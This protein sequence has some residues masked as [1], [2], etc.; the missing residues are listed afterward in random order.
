M[1][2]LVL[3][4]VVKTYGRK[5]ALKGISFEIRSGSLVGLLGPNGAGKTTT[6]KLIAGLLKKDSGEI[7]VNGKD[8]YTQHS[9]ALRSV[10]ILIEPS[11]FPYLTAY[12]NLAYLCTALG[13]DKNQIDP[14]LEFV[15][16]S[17]ERNKKV[18]TFSFGMKQRLGLAQALLGNPSLII[19]D[20]PNTGLDPI[21][22]IELK[23]LLKE[24]VREGKTVVLSTHVLNIVEDLCSN[25]IFINEGEIIYQGELG[26]ILS[27]KK[28]IR[29]EGKPIE[30]IKEILTNL[31]INFSLSNGSDKIEFIISNEEIDNV[32]QV[33]NSKDCKIAQIE[34][35][36]CNLEEIF[37][38]LIGRRLK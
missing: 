37:A 24:L 20:E 4:N 13:Y 29:L 19:L 32:L 28:K 12:D 31:N 16:L 23:D 7:L 10:G 9:D 36:G 6:I 25:V 33:L 38:E 35:L 3:K 11:F 21:G 14:L 1:S 22:I 2:E 34:K 5:I 26:K 15:G 17:N 27:M 18:S 8:P 30:K